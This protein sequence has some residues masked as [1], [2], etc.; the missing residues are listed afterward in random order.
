MTQTK[1]MESVEEL[2]IEDDAISLRYDALKPIESSISVDSL[3][4]TSSYHISDSN[5]N[6]MKIISFETSGNSMDNNLITK[7]KA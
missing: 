2:Q 4:S 7:K 1:P 3:E 5:K 6:N